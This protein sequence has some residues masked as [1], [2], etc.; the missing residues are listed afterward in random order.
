MPGVADER[1][2]CVT[3]HIDTRDVS[4]QRFALIEGLRPVWHL[5]QG[6]LAVVH[7]VYP[8]NHTLVL[9]V[10]ICA[11]QNLFGLNPSFSVLPVVV[12]ELL[13]PPEDFVF[14]ARSCN[15]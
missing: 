2:G 4:F 14:S 7:S 15:E 11:L 12:G 5:S 6:R 8:H 10:F 3:G 1:T 13:I 9:R